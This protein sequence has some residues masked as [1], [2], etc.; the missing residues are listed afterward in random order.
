MIVEGFQLGRDCG[1][2]G[3]MVELDGNCLDDFCRLL[4]FSCSICWRVGAKI[5]GKKK[6][7][8]AFD[9]QKNY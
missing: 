7:W 3:G 4:V 8:W 5:V 6:N 1:L 9:V 2:W